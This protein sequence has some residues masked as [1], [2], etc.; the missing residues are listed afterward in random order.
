MQNDECYLCTGKEREK[1]GHTNCHLKIPVLKCDECG[2]V[3]L[4]SFEHI[5][6][7]YY[8]RSGMRSKELNPPELCDELN[9]EKFS[10]WRK[11]T[12]QDDLRRYERLK[13]KIINKDILDFGAGNGGFLKIA[14]QTANSVTAVEVDRDSR[15]NMN[16][17]DI[18]TFQELASIPLD[19]KFD[20][21]TSFHVFEHL[22]DPLDTLK[23]LSAYLN[24]EGTLILEFPNANDALISLYGS[25]EFSEFTYRND[26]LFLFNTENTKKMI[27]KASL[28]CKKVSQAQRFPLS[29]HLYWLS[30]GKAGGHKVWNFLNSE[31][32]NREYKKH[33]ENMGVCDTIIV[34]IKK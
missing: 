6:D 28:T 7:D 19:T 22:K 33:L 32:L 26:H 12:Q 13:D 27:E 24:K 20:V 31:I 9:C 8:H 30:K 16:K 11:I 17:E 21:I 29:N 5:E 23:R 10:E 2:L 15:M 4:E 18:L 25:K 34:E 14:A 3:F 1:I